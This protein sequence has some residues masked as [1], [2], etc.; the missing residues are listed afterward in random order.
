MEYESV[1]SWPLIR[2]SFCRFFALL[3]RGVEAG[4]R[5]RLGRE[6]DYGFEPKTFY[7]Y[8]SS[9]VFPMACGF[10]ATRGDGLREFLGRS[11]ECHRFAVSI[12]SHQPARFRAGDA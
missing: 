7:F 1:D 12:P 3:R 8:E 10:I 6:S 5:T 9:T 2:L 11:G 4:G